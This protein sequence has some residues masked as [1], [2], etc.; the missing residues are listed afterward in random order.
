M[1][2]LQELTSDNG[3]LPVPLKGWPRCWKEKG[4]TQLKSKVYLIEVIALGFGQRNQMSSFTVCSIHGLK[5]EHKFSE[6][7]RN[8]QL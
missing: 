5:Q 8:I 1:A 4:K 6:S 3:H 7:N 2:G